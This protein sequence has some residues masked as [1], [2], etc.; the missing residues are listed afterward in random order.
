LGRRLTSDSTV[1]KLQTSWNFNICALD[2][3]GDENAG[4]KDEGGRM[5]DDKGD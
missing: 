4:K 5:K 2:S 1:R 3:G